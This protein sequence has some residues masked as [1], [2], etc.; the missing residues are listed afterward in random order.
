MPET[1]SG[2]DK[3]INSI[4]EEA[5]LEAEASKSRASREIEHILN[6]AKV[7]SASIIAAAEKEC[8]I[9]ENSVLLKN[10]TN[11]EIDAKKY[12]LRKKRDLLAQSYAHALKKLYS[13][14]DSEI[15]SILLKILIREAEGGELVVSSSVHKNIVS[16]IIF[17]G[18]AA[19]RKSGLS[20]LIFSDKSSEDLRSGFM[21]VGKGFFKRCSFEDII[22]DFKETE[23][24][25]VAKILF[26]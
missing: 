10:R 21:L 18:N 15:R 13:L 25:Y 23:D 5:K 22:D 12:L 17:D 7:E 4:I 3:L 19:L 2:A 9:Y 6:R 20:P 16:E 24:G 11:A 1:V 14:S 26:E 8:S